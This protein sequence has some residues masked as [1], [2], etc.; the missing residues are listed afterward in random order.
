M[1]D[2][3]VILW[4]VYDTLVAARRGDLDS[5]LRREAE[6]QAA[7]DRTVKNFGIHAEPTQ[8]HELFVRGIEAER[9]MRIAEGIPHPEV[10]VDEIW[11]KILEKFAAEETPTL[12]FAREVAL[13]FE[14]QA[15]PKELQFRAYDVLTTLRGRGFI[16]GIISNGQF[17]TPIELSELLGE[18]SRGAIRT[19]ESVFDPQ[20]VFFS[21][22]LGVAKPDPTALQRAV[23]TLAEYSIMPDD[24]VMIGN[25]LV[26]DVAP[27]Q[28]FGFRTVLFAPQ[29]VPEST[30]KADLVIHNLGQ[31]LEWL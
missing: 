7:F 18:A 15:N 4:D 8:L 6:L 9:Q 2:T 16:Q 11:F 14:R 3:K 27:A 24:C 25:S 20:L 30:I 19:Y 5:L 31:L 13:F 12:N 10:R 23:K 28:H 26:N 17:Y 22:D 29:P 21:Y 1:A